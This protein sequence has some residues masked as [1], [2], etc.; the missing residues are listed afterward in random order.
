MKYNKL[1]IYVFIII[2]LSISV[3]ADIIVDDFTGTA[4]SNDG[5]NNFKC[6][7]IHF[8]AKVNT[9]LYNV[10]KNPLVNGLTLYIYNTSLNNG[11]MLT[12]A[13]PTGN[14]YI[15]N[16][17]TLI[18]GTKY[19]L[20]FNA[21][22]AAGN[23]YIQAKTIPFI[24]TAINVTG[25]IDGNTIDTGNFLENFIKIATGEVAAPIIFQ[26]PTPTNNEAIFFTR[27]NITINTT[28][29]LT[30]TSFNI[31]HKL[32]YEN[33]SIATQ[34][35]N[36]SSNNVTNQFNN[37]GT[38]KYYINATINNLTYSQNTE[39]RTFTIYN[40]SIPNITNPI[41][42]TNITRYL[43]ISWSNSTT[44]NN[45]VNLTNFLIYINNTL[46]N[47]TANL[48]LT[49]YDT[50]Y[51]NISLGT[52]II[53]IETND[54]NGNKQ[55][56]TNTFINHPTN[57]ELNITAIGVN[58]STI[59]TFNST[60]NGVLYTTTNSI[61]RADLIKNTNYTIT[62]NNT[63]YA[64]TST[65]ITLQN[66]TQ[67]Y[68][69][70]VYPEA[71]LL[72]NI[73]DELTGYL[74]NQTITITVTDITNPNIVTSST[75]NGT[76]LIQN[77]Y[78]TDLLEVRF[79]STN[80]TNS[81]N[82]QIILPNSYGTL[83]AY[84]LP[85]SSAENFSICW[86]D[87][88]GVPIN[89]LHVYQWFLTNGSYALTQDVYSDINGRISFVFTDTHYYLYNFSSTIYTANPFILNPPSNSNTLS[90]GCN[91]D[92]T[93]TFSEQTPTYSTANITGSASFNNN[94]NILTFTYTS[95]NTS[96]STYYYN[97]TKIVNGREVVLCSES[98][99]STTD[100]FTCDLTGYYDTIQ[101]KGYADNQIF[102]GG[103]IQLNPSDK[104]FDNMDRKDASYIAGFIMLIIIFAGTFLGI[105]GTMI[106]G[107]IGLIIITWLGLVE[108]LTITLIIGAIIG[109]IVINIGLKRFR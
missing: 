36:T 14:D 21:S 17:M 88:N 44:T 47:T 68:R 98:S 94:T 25:R 79:N 51:N 3:K 39:T 37:L 104:L 74:I 101:V 1:W 13:S 75:N 63:D 43:N 40:I 23:R 109:T 81:R 54:T 73:Y 106:S 22:T 78:T 52:L 105:L 95:Y 71:S 69:F 31:T 27:N 16:N 15:T 86:Y 32:Y 42:N 46:I 97:V 48:S 83:N 107:I 70:T 41:N 64:Y 103:Y 60:I 76:V 100:I 28:S 67:G 57:A 29:N 4:N 93:L 87:T 59:N 33:G 9:V 102:Y 34:I 77:L 8:I 90:S 11:I 108:P 53:R 35:I 30:G 55:N 2:I 66:F 85:K 91:Y 10:S 20:C 49:N 6:E 89:N 82:Y 24:G 7:G 62:F 92:V 58:G 80:Y 50:Y 84:L 96:Y 99:S 18:N 26:T 61:I 5:G 45:S 19:F 12:V 72:V 38:G 65:I 56:S